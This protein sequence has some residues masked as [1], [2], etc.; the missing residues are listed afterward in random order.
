[1]QDQDEYDNVYKNKNFFIGLIAIIPGAFVGS[2]IRLKSK[3]SEA[4]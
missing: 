4:P 2:Y 3:I 1:M